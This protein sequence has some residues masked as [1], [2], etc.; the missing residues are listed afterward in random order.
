[1]RCMRK[2]LAVAIISILFTGGAFAGIYGTDFMVFQPTVDGKDFM[3]VQS[4]R[5]LASGRL[6]VGAFLDGAMNTLVLETPSGEEAN[7]GFDRKGPE[8]LVLNV[9]GH[10]AFGLTSWWSIGVAAPWIVADEELEQEGRTLYSGRGLTN[11]RAMTKLKLYNTKKFYLGL[12]VHVDWEQTEGNPF[13]GD[14]VDL[15][16]YTGELIMSYHGSQWGLALNVGYRLRNQGSQFTDTVDNNEV[17]RFPYIFPLGN[18]ITYNTGVYYK[19]SRKWRLLWEVYGN[20][21]LEDTVLNSTRIKG[22]LE[23]MIG[24]RWYAAKRFWLY[25]AAGTEILH[26][27]GSS[28]ARVVAGFN[29]QIPV[30]G[31]KRKIK[32]TTLK[33]VKEPAPEPEP[34]PAPESAPEP[35]PEPAKLADA[36]EKINVKNV[37]F[38]TNSAIIDWNPTTTANLNEALESIKKV[39][40]KLKNVIVAGHTDSRGKDSYNMSLSQK[41]AESVKRW[42]I[43]QGV[44]GNMLQAT[45]YGET[46]PIADNTTEGGRYQNR[47]VELGL[48]FK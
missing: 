15:P 23:T 29:W 1:M 35:V 17:E 44:D 21:Q 14:E 9:F 38:K 4:G 32:K 10:A 5:N 12:A 2:L 47:R 42:F 37:L 24:V 25:A 20:S 6:N 13:V 16:F 41:R 22:A 11:V 27:V 34:M 26:S 19:M 43:K 45:G 46:Q 7:N 39:Q 28:D 18:Q 48:F 31:N 40:D 33:P 3:A 36:D 30:W 8:N